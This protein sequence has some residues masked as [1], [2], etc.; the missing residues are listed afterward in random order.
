MRILQLHNTYQQRGGED[1]VV[2]A[3]AK[4]LRDHG[5]TVDTLI[6]SN[7][8]IAGIAS[9]LSTVISLR[10][11]RASRDLVADRIRT[12][13]PDLLHVHNTFPRL[14]ASVY[15][16]AAALGVPVVQT[17]HNFRLGCSNGFLLRDD[18]VCEKC[19]HGSPYWGAL[20]ACYRHSR[21]A[22]FFVADMIAHHRR[23]N[24]YSRK[25]DRFIALTE[26]SRGKFVELGLP[27]SRI[28]VKPNFVDDPGP[29]PDS[30]RHGALF[31]GRLSA[32]KGIETLLE[33]WREID[34]PLT[35]A[36][37]GPLLERVRT[38]GLKNVTVAGRL[39]AMEIKALMSAAAMLIFP[40]IWY[41]GMPLTIVEAFAQ[42]LPVVGSNIGNISEMLIGG[43]GRLFEA[44][45]ASALRREVQQLIEDTALMR[46]LGRE[47]RFL[48]EAAFSPEANYRQLMKIYGEVSN[49]AASRATPATDLSAG[50]L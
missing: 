44:G 15:D 9:Q 3:E 13:R 42:G 40:S 47:A 38:F 29:A 1:V 33:A 6:V 8:V 27:A 31:A 25:V 17:L 4:L 19:W 35:I 46:S 22:S 41:E 20:H 18:V 49:S 14:T 39:Q 11:S 7:D 2:A 30:P 23:R 12:F 37:D 34:Y 43:G 45:S 5:Q 24:T 10:Y 28:S 26:F 48:Y 16:A 36:G 32:E 50:G 21:P